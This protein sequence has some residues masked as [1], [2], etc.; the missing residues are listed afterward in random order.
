MDVVAEMG[1]LDRIVIG[2]GKPSV[3]I[4]FIVR[5]VGVI[6]VTT[7]V[8]AAAHLDDH[9]KGTVAAG[10]FILSI[11]VPWWLAAKKLDANAHEEWAAFL[12][13]PKSPPE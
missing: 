2:L 6:V 5:V 8:G 11:A 13:D 10:L 4:G 9:E 12:G 3:W 1:L 7:V